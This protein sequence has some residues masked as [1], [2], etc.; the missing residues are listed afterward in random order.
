MA[1]LTFRVPAVR[2]DYDDI[3]LA[4]LEPAI[5]WRDPAAHLHACRRIHATACPG[6]PTALAS[7]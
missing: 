6:L 1:E 2:V 3:E 7:G 4:G 5:S